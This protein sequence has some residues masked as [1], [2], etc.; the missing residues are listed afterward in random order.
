MLE[1]Y[2]CDQLGRSLADEFFHLEVYVK[3]HQVLMCGVE[4]T[5][6]FYGSVHN[7]VREHCYGYEEI[8]S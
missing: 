2:G 6:G 8:K 3:T 7:K 1:N 5:V 4:Y